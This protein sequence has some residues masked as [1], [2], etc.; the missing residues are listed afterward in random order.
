MEAHLESCA[1]CRGTCDGLR[2]LLQTCRMT[3]TP[4]VPAEV[5]AAVRRAVQSYLDAQRPG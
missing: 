2:E 5:Q 4:E 3:S 1:G